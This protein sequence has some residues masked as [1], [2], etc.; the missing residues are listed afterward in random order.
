MLRLVRL[1]LPLVIVCIIMFLVFGRKPSGNDVDRI[2][3]SGILISIRGGEVERGWFKKDSFG[4]RL[5]NGREFVV[6]LGPDNNNERAVLERE[7]QQVN[8]P[9]E[10]LQPVISDSVSAM[11][12]SLLLPV[13]VI[14]FFWMFVV[15]QTRRAVQNVPGV[16]SVTTVAIPLALQQFVDQRVAAGGHGSADDYLRYLVREDQKRTAEGV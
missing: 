2:G 9:F 10:F 15:R 12:V 6:Y 13:L 14:L 4:G 3:F 5:M 7:L 8:V 16:G 11:I 1:L